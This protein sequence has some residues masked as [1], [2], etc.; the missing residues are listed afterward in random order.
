MLYGYIS[1][2]FYPGTNSSARSSLLFTEFNLKKKSS[3][4]WAQFSILDVD[5]VR[6]LLWSP[7]LPIFIFQFI[8]TSKILQT[9][10]RFRSSSGYR[11]AGLTLQICNFF[12]PNSLFILYLDSQTLQIME[13]WNKKK[14]LEILSGSVTTWEERKIIHCFG[15]ITL[16]QNWKSEKL[17][18]FKLRCRGI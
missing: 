18:C 14:M 3:S 10:I 15:L 7:I 16:C 6:W 4:M 12:S 11:K 1:F 5:L 9:P 17:I 13:I 8:I 2:Y